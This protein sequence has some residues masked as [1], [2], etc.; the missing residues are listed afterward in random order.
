MLQVDFREVEEARSSQAG[1]VGFCEGESDG[2]GNDQRLVVVTDRHSLIVDDQSTLIDAAS[3]RSGK[4]V[5]CL[6][7]ALEILCRIDG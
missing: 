1:P 3:A 7:R 2:S 5:T 6:A 4:S